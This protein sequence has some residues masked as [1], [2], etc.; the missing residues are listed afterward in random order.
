MVQTLRL[1]RW[2][3]VGRLTIATGI[4][5][6]ALGTWSSASA[7]S[8]LIA[9]L[10]LLLA[11]GVTLGSIWYTRV[12]KRRATRSFLYGQLVFDT[13]LV[14]AIVHITTVGPQPSDFSA[15]YV[16]VIAA[17][18]L[19]LPLPGGMLIGALACLLYVADALWLQPEFALTTGAA[20]QIVLFAVI[21]LVTAAL[22]SRLRRSWKA[23]GEAESELRQL[24]LDTTDI[25]AAIDTGLITID[26]VGR[27]VH[28][29]PAA[30]LVL[31]LNVE[32]W[33]GKPVVD[34]LDRLVPGLGTVIARTG[35]TKV[36]VRR[37]E[38]RIPSAEGDRFLGL[39]TNLQPRRGQPWVTAVLA[40][41]TEFKQ[42]DEL[43]RRAER[44]QAIAEL[45]ASLA[46][47]IKN[48]LAS[49]RSSVE[50]LAGDRLSPDDRSVLRRLVLAESDRLTRLLS[51]FMEFSRL[52]LRRW[53]KLDLSV[54]A[55][56]AV[57]LV[58]QHP[59]AGNGSRI[60][61]VPPV[62]PVV[63][64]GDHDLLHRALFNLLLNAV[65]HAGPAGVVRLEI[66]RVAELDLP[67]SVPVEAPVRITVH[68]N[69]PG[70]RDEDIPNLF[71]PFY[72]T[73]DGGNGLGLALVHRAVEAHSGA[74]LVD[75]NAGGGAKFTV[76]LPG[77]NGRRR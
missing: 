69:G 53:D 29:N 11:L 75:G 51:E 10:A 49:I 60:E 64:D 13:L 6:G 16:L 61:F 14:T 20:G 9:T 23:L 4:F 31:G 47:E 52:E 76:Y 50:Q 68:D 8:T 43:I 62:E 57:G 59:D 26:G 19:L 77:H 22:G 1:L 48:P 5:A 39:R 24:R 18:A 38:L 40:D 30:E 54:V 15:L 2:L 70:I 56:D 73:R 71:N 58:R 32:H 55:G 27:L 44:L 74:I 35:E 7:E 72:T 28:C 37:H 67:R 65:Q 12:M 66:G 3:Y 45:G 42:V 34:E 33:R 63:V 21:A 17:G 41:V 36:P 25:L 46:H